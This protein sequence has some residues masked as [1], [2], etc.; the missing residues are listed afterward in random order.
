MSHSQG[1]GPTPVTGDWVV[2]A[3]GPCEVDPWSIQAVLPRRSA[4]TR[5]SA[6]HGRGEQ[7]LAANVDRL[8]IVHSLESA[9]NPRRLERYLAV[10]WESGASPELVLSKSDLADD[11][12]GALSV[13]RRVALGVPLWVVSTADRG[14]LK[15]IRS[16]L[17]RGATVALLGPSGAG[18]STL[19]N[20]L[21]GEE[22]AATG[23][24]REGDKKG[25]HTTTARQ[26]IRIHNGALLLDTPG[27]RELRVLALDEGLDHAFP[28]IDALAGQCRFRDCT[29]EAEPGC[30]VLRAVEEGRLSGERLAS[31]KKLQAEVA[32][33]LRRSDPRARKAALAETKTALKTLKRH[34]HKYRR[35]D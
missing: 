3:R 23:E 10:A 24:V 11:V 16:S 30:A 28:E 8:W 1:G 35:E 7:I 19:V 34:H 25:R 6:G 18:K 2:A 9:P 26:L 27:L 32:A 21:A 14:S 15:E 12:E 4:V 33:E 5:G 20:E 22:V 13:A 29:H 17:G 31:F